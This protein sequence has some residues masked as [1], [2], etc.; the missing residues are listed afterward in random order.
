MTYTY[1]IIYLYRCCGREG[2]FTGSFFYYTDKKISDCEL[3][4]VKKTIKE[5]SD[6]ARAEGKRGFMVDYVVIADIKLLK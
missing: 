4:D 2:E 3:A 6:L 5:I 1:L